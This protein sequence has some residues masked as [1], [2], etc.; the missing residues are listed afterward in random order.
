MLYYFSKLGITKPLSNTGSVGKLEEEKSL[1][2]ENTLRD[3]GLFESTVETRKREEV[4]G[5]LNQIIKK[6]IYDCCIQQVCDPLILNFVLRTEK[7][8]NF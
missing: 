8:N 5:K 1:E 3:F 6:W 7:N 2:L 4:L